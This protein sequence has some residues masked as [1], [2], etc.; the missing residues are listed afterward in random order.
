[1]A[2]AQL[3]NGKWMSAECHINHIRAASSCFS[4]AI[5]PQNQFIPIEPPRA[6][7]TALG[8]WYCNV[9][10]YTHAKNKFIDFRSSEK[11]QN[12]KDVHVIEQ[13]GTAMI[14]IQFLG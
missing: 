13:P 7:T 14:T 10:A 1:M 2:G 11:G 9:N 12:T 8:I 6:S 3:T 4:A 5:T